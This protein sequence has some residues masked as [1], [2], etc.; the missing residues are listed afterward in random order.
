[1]AEV[2]RIVS[3]LHDSPDPGP[4]EHA[5]ALA[6]AVGARGMKF[7]SYSRGGSVAELEELFARRLGKERAVFMPTGTLANHLA[8]RA[9]AGGRK[10]V[11]L[12]E[13]SHLYNDT[14]DCLGTLSG[15]SAVPLGKG[16]ASFTLEEVQEALAQ[17]ES[18][19][20]KTGIGAIS[21]E[22]PV[23][24]M[25]GAMFDRQQMLGIR[26]YARSRGIALHLD[27]AR[28]FIESAY[29]GITPL[30]YAADFDTVYISLYKY[31]GAVSGAMLAGPASLLDELYHER[32]MFGGA[33]NQAWILVAPV[34]EALEYFGERFAGAVERYRELKLH[35]D[36]MEELGIVEVPNGTNVFALELGEGIDATEFRDSLRGMGILL[37]EAQGRVFELRVNTSIAE[38]PCA[39]ITACFKKAVA[40]SRR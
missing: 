15:I 16:S 6:S 35:L 36:G 25:K 11:L 14:G 28:L 24:R 23:R 2:E 31:F 40:A 8:V 27:G 10:R 19:R 17:A 7:D 34:F 21:I 30:E 22:T 13:R 32:R 1:M 20:V 9:L 4:A 26:G 29:S 37:P 18:G 12:Q 5:A 38:R 39:D 33:L 3:F